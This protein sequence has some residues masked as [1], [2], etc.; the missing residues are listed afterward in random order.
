MKERIQTQADEVVNNHLE[1][2][3]HRLG[4]CGCHSCSIKQQKLIS[5]WFRNHELSDEMWEDY[6]KNLADE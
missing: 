5:G 6:L 2:E 4:E 1:A 3:S